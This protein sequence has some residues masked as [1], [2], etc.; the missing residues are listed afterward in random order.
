MRSATGTAKRREREAAPEAKRA[1]RR[2]ADRDRKR[3]ERSATR[4]DQAAT[5]P[6]APD[7]PDN[8]VEFAESLTVSQG[9]HEGELLTLLPWEREYLERVEASAGGELGLSVA[10]GAG[11]TTLVATIAAAAV[12]GPLARRRAAAVI[13]AGSFAQAC[14]GFD[15]ARSFLQETIAADPDRWRVLRSEQTALIQDRATGAELRAREA[16]ARTLH[17][18]APGLVIGDEPA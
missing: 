7:L 8:L 16:S 17:G 15:T 13:V 3:A 2:K 4:R 11:K 18:L 6:P 5:L 1:R 14:I 10:A 9:E 12:A